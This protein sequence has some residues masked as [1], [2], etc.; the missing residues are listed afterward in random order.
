VRPDTIPRSGLLISVLLALTAAANAEDI[1]SDYLGRWDVTLETPEREL[2]TWLE[3]TQLQ[4]KPAVRMVGRWGHARMLP[5]AEYAHDRIRFVSPKEEEGRTDDMVFEGR[6]V[7]KSLVGE[8]HGPDGTVWKWRGERAPA[9][10]RGG[11]PKWGKPVSLFNGRDLHGWHLSDPKA[12]VTWRVE[13][14]SLVSAG[15]GAELLTDRQF[16]DFKLH[17]E[18]NAAS[19]ANS[20]VYLR[21]RYEVQV[22]N[23]AQG[24]PPE[25]ALG[26]VYGF[27][28]PSTSPSRKPG[29]RVYDITLVGRRVTV[30]LDGVTL[31]DGQE[32]PGVTGGA[33]DSREGSPG[34]LYLQ[35]SEQGRVEY[36]NIL[37]TPAIPAH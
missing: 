1:P 28:A 8:T 37:V 2:P 13:N 35:G 33:L 16:E 17:I 22:E 15:Q 31:I 24:E 36:R 3:I 34:P 25:R 29:W 20:G 9:L 4:G 32:I 19:G 21:G 7:G 23:G 11:T 26:G 27:L 10:T 12:A 14:G 6:L 30:V 18:F 5:S